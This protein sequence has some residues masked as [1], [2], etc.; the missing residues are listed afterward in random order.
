MHWFALVVLTLFLVLAVYNFVYFQK[1]KKG[2]D[3]SKWSHPGEVVNG[4]GLAAAVLAF[5]YWGWH[6]Y[7]DGKF[8]GM[9]GGGR[10]AVYA[11]S[12][13]DF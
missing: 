2:E 11:Y 12:P 6:V 1:V 9:L 7:H 4:A 3:V 13:F 10:S 8:A 5:A